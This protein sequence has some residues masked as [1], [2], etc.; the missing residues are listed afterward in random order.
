MYSDKAEFL[1]IYIK[2]AHPAEDWPMRVNP[3]LKYIKDPTSKFERFQVANTC[4]NDLKI[5]IPCLLDDMENST[6]AAY[7]GYPDRL[8]IVG[9]DGRIAYHGG[10]GPRGFQ[11]DEMEKTLVEI[12]SITGD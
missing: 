11:P 4:V 6:A 10:P 1:I 9:K 7:K 12:L 8:Y 3:R 5:S 2:E